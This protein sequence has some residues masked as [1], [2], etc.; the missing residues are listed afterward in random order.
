MCEDEFIIPNL[1]NIPMRWGG[2]GGGGGGGALPVSCH[3]P[4]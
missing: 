4:I 2:G 1:S 3:L